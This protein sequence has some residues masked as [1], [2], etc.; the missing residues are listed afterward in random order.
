MCGGHILRQETR[1]PAPQADPDDTR[2]DHGVTA[3]GLGFGRLFD[4]TMDAIIVADTAGRIVLWNGAASRILGHS[5]EEAVGRKVDMIVPP[6]FVERHREGMRRFRETGHGKMID[7]GVPLELPALHRDG[8]EVMVEMTLSDVRSDG[9]HY[10]LAILRD[11]TDRERLRQAVDAERNALRAANESLEAFAYVVSHDL[12]EPVRGV[13]AY[14]EELRENP[15]APD[16]DELLARAIDSNHR[17]DRLLR[18]LLD[19]SRAIGGTIETHPVNVGDAL[20]DPSCSIQF[21][22]LMEERRAHLLLA[23]DLPTVSA[24]P[25]LLCQVLGNLITNAVK[26]NPKPHPRVWVRA[27]E[28]TETEA[29]IIVEDDGPGFPP[30]ILAR[31]ERLKDRPSTVQGGFGLAIARRVVT[32]LNGRML[33]GNGSGDGGA[34]VCVWLPK[35]R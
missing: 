7:A 18:G 16:R 10:V 33:I 11:I 14:L 13:A 8:H 19:W 2:T 17:L 3:R 34:R 1:M 32:R 22:H 4:Q 23:E 27:G 20:R 6:Q 29:Q 25:P 30:E 5:T 31:F 24:T 28:E 15:D 21:Q 9:G 26:H 35:A 12:K